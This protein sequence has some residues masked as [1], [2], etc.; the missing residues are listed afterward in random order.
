MYNLESRSLSL[1]ERP[2]GDTSALFGELDLNYL[3]SQAFKHICFISRFSSGSYGVGMRALA[4][5][6]RNLSLARFVLASM[7]SSV[8]LFDVVIRCSNGWS[9]G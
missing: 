8:F 5:F 2:V 3:R 1:F 4:C 9:G 7:F 6:T